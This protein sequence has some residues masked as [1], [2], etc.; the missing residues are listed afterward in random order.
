MVGVTA[1]DRSG[2]NPTAHPGVAAGGESVAAGDSVRRRRVHRGRRRQSAV[3][4]VA[5]LEPVEAQAGAEL[6]AD[7]LRE[8]VEEIG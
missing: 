5:E 6:H 4:N 2:A 1:A 7:L 3:R 8:G